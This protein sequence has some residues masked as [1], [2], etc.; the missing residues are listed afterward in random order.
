ME[1]NSDNEKYMLC[2]LID[3]EDPVKTF[4][5]DNMPENILDGEEEKSI[6]KGKIRELALTRYMDIEEKLKKT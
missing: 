5:E 1:R 3:M 2:V 4:E 6:L